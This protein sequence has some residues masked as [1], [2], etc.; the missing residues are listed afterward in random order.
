MKQ[1]GSEGIN[2]R[3]HSGKSMPSPARKI[4]YVV[5]IIIM[6]IILYLVR[7][8]ENWNLH[9]LTEDF[10]RA[11]FYIEL[12]IYA[13]I[14]VNILFIF[15]DNRWFK[16]LVQTITDITGALSLIMFYVIF[17]L[18]LEDQTWVKWIRIGL[19]ILFG[20]TLISALVNLVKGIRYLVKE[21][22][23]V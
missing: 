10:S 5:V 19:L 11:L 4:G 6:F 18:N 16:H 12:S 17:P 1:S 13:N 15:Y 9:F 8:W 22:E 23:A 7:R 14:G 20:L 3:S 21:P 2:K